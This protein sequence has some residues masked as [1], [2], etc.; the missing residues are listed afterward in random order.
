VILDELRRAKNR[1]DRHLHG[2]H[3][4]PIEERPDLRLSLDNYRTRCSTCHS[5][6]TM[7]ELK[8]MQ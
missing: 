1:N 4:I 2:D 6:K 8:G 3:Q 7:R 5:A